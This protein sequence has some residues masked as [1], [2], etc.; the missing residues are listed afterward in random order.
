MT[1][2]VYT[3]SI[4]NDCCVC[5]LCDSFKDEGKSLLSVYVT[6]DLEANIYSKFRTACDF[7]GENSYIEIYYAVEMFPCAVCSSSNVNY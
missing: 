5:P 2:W 6:D 7:L 4:N 1:I 3:S